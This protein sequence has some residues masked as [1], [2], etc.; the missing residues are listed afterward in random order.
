ME[1][2]K[3][4]NKIKS[5][6]EFLDYM[7]KLRRS[8]TDEAKKVREDYKDNPSEN[9]GSVTQVNINSPSLDEKKLDTNT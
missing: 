7:E 5:E 4:K 3:R 1:K 2:R 6:S 8:M 9:S